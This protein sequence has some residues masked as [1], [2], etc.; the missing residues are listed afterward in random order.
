[1]GTGAAVGAAVGVLI[2]ALLP[3]GGPT[4]AAVGAA[5]G[6]FLGAVAGR[7]LA[8]RVVIDDWEPLP[9]PQSY[10]GARV[11]DVDASV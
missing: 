11:P 1:M 3:G 10:V 8:A 9:T 2:G 4:S 7:A 5:A 6:G